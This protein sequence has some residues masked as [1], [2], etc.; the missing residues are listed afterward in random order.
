VGS[1]GVAIKAVGPVTI[2]GSSVTITGNTNVVGVL[3]VN[4]VP[5][6]VP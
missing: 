2:T 5:V 6:T 3:S 1:A 4:G